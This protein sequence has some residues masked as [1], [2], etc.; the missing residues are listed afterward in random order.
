MGRIRTRKKA[1]ATF[2]SPMVSYNL[3]DSCKNT[4][5]LSVLIFILYV[6]TVYRCVLCLC[7]VIVS[8][9]IVS[10]KLKKRI[11]PSEKW[12]ECAGNTHWDYDCSRA[13]VSAYPR[14]FQLARRSEINGGVPSECAHDDAIE[15]SLAK[16]QTI[17]GAIQ[18]ST[19]PI[20]ASLEDRMQKSEISV[21]AS[22]PS[23]GLHW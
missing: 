20:I 11:P 16:A 17:L 7:T 19:N 6:I 14:R 18:A 23:A 13:I 1:P 10:R 9:L 3:A 21:C 8:Y 2:I 4:S 12:W 22:Y 15:C 5:F